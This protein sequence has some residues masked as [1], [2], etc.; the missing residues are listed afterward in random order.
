V[1]ALALAYVYAE[2]LVLAGPDAVAE[3][4]ERLGCDGAA[5][6]LAYHPARLWLPRYGVVRHSPPGAVSF[7]PSPGRYPESLTP[8]RTA[9]DATVRA[10]HAF[11]AALSDR[12][13]AFHA[14]LV[15]LHSAPLV[16]ARPDLAATTSDGTATIHA[17]CPAHDEVLEYMAALVGDVCGQFA[18]DGVELEATLPAAWEPSYT[19][20]LALDEPG[21]EARAALGA[22]ACAACRDA[23][24]SH[25]RA[26]IAARAVQAVAGAARAG[27]APARVLLFGTPVELRAQGAGPDALRAADGVGIGV[28]ATTGEAAVDHFSALAALA[29]DRPLTASVNWAPGRTPEAMAADVRALAGAGARGVALYHLSLVPEDGLPALAAAARAARESCAPVGGRA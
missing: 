1:S 16:A 28:G 19:V 29:G 7:A 11:R 9:D 24:G 20:T 27:G 22:C 8:R 12:G 10:V 15:L 3:R 4:L 21:P 18:P 23:G 5:L 26:A 13:L 17:L 2:E 14:W 6:A 25:A